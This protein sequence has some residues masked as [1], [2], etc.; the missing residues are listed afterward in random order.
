MIVEYCPILSIAKKIGK[1]SDCPHC[2]VCSMHIL[3]QKSSL[4][5]KLTSAASVGSTEDGAL[6]YC[7]ESSK[8][9]SDIVFSLLLAEHTN[10]QL[11]VCGSMT[12]RCETEGTEKKKERIAL[13]SF[14]VRA[15]RSYRR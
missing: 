7:A 5:W 15:K 13:V 12:A 2:I 6:L 10:E 9:L 3:T 8:Q 4:M 11:S 1:K 14:R